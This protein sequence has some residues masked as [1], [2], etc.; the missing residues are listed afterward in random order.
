MVT[1][2]IWARSGCF[3]G[4]GASAKSNPTKPSAA[5]NV[6]FMEFL[7]FAP[8]VNQPPVGIVAVL[9]LLILG[10]GAAGDVAGTIIKIAGNA[11]FRGHGRSRFHYWRRRTSQTGIDG[12][13]AGVPENG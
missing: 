6:G 2:R 4:G 5:T 11:I 1:R 7:L 9:R 13:M 12:S 10:V 8:S 3:L